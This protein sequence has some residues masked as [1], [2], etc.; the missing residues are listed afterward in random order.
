MQKCTWGQWKCISQRWP[1][2][3][4]LQVCGCVL[5]A[6][7]VAAEGAWA[8]CSGTRVSSFCQL[9]APLDHSHLG[10]LM[11]VCTDYITWTIRAAL[12][13]LAPQRTPNHSP[14]LRHSILQRVAAGGVEGCKRPQSSRYELCRVV[15]G[16]SGQA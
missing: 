11:R 6:T 8:S 14:Q 16:R 5:H 3:K 2:C 15:C 1:L 7:K 13:C 12:N 10:H 4:L 9:P